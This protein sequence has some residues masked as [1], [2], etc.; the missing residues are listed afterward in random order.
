M[1]LNDRF[2]LRFVTDKSLKNSKFV[3][4]IYLVKLH[5]VRLTR[6]RAKHT[7][8]LIIQRMSKFSTFNE[9]YSREPFP[10]FKIRSINFRE[11]VGILSESCRFD[12]TG[13]GSSLKHYSSFQFGPSCYYRDD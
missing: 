10:P 2:V 6:E 1:I 5:S 7:V 9:F 4:R 12:G 13:T 11:A 8:S 3:E